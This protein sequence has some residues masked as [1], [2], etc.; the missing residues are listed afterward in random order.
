MARE[1]SYWARNKLQILADYLPRFNS[2]SQRSAQRI[3]LDL[4]AG[5]PDNVE[6]HTGVEFDG[7]P[8]VA[9][10]AQPGFTILRFGELGAKADKL[11]AV[12]AERFP[13]DNRYRVVKGDSNE[14]IDDSLRWWSA[15]PERPSC[16]D[17][18]IIRANFLF[19]PPRMA[20]AGLES[21]F[22]RCLLNRCAGQAP[23][24]RIERDR[25]FGGL[26]LDRNGR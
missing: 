22:Q 24:I 6:R 7:S 13:G 18:T 9:L 16:H 15:P 17:H 11:S 19:S 21:F 20:T 5:E 1:W 26:F 8:T 2:A 10:G 25:G 3:Y 23:A 14:T 4:M 12:L